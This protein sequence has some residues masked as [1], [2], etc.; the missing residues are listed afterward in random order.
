VDFR[1][2]DLATDL[3]R[4]LGIEAP[5]DL[6]ARVDELMQ[7]VLTEWSV[8]GDADVRGRLRYGSWT[9]D[10]ARCERALEELGAG[11]IQALRSTIG[12]AGSEAIGFGLAPRSKQRLRWW[13]LVEDE[14]G[15]SM[16]ED[17]VAYEPA[18]RP[19]Y[20]LMVRAT[21]H[22]D[23]CSAVGCASIDGQVSRSTLYFELPT[24]ASVIPILEH[25]GCPPSLR[26]N[27]FF[28]GLLGLDKGRRRPWP[29]VW[30]GRSVGKGGGWK[31][32][33]FA[34]KEPTRVSDELLVQLCGET[35]RTPYNCFRRVACGE[36]T[37]TPVIQ[38]VGLTFLDDG[39]PDLPHWTMYLADDE[40]QE[41][42]RTDDQPAPPG[43]EAIPLSK[44][45]LIDTE[46]HT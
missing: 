37:T 12:G 30:V 33:Y 42:A 9:E 43:L 41:P 24:P 36:D 29:K 34:R 21:D 8:N 45:N 26:A 16:A 28:R 4:V 6:I 38:I 20:D 17:I 44:T 40:V 5:T 2:S 19:D 15:A 39:R 7:P 14:E 35:N 31:F 46:Q 11:G 32:Y 13:R 3:S 10:P 25:I 18:L 23:W 1:V 27:Q 22:P